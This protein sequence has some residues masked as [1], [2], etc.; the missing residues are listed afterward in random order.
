M[1]IANNKNISIPTSIL[2]ID[3]KP[4]LVDISTIKFGKIPTTN[5]I[6]ATINHKIENFTGILPLLNNYNVTKNINKPV[7]RTKSTVPKLIISTS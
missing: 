4:I 2:D 5:K 6:T 7:P 3:I 1:H